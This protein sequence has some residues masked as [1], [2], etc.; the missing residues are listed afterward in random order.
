MSILRSLF[1]VRSVLFLAAVL[2]AVAGAAQPITPL[3]GYAFAPYD[4]APAG[5][6]VVSFDFDSSGDLYTLTGDPGWALGLTVYRGVGAGRTVLYDSDA[7]LPGSRV[8]V[9]GPWL[10]FNDGGDGGTRWDSNYYVL[11]LSGGAPILA[12]TTVEGTPSLWGA[13]T[14][15]GA[16]FFASGATG[17]GPSEIFHMPLSGTGALDNLVSIGQP[18]DASG[19]VAFDADGNLFYAPRYA[20]SGQPNVF[21]WTAAE[22][23]AALADPTGAPLLPAGHVWGE[24]PAPFTGASGM[25][26]DT[27]GSVYVTANVWGAPGELLVFRADAEGASLAPAALG[28]HAARLE[29]LRLRGGRVY[30]NC[31]EGVY[32]I[33]EVLTV[34]ADGPLE[35]SA[36]MGE[37]A[38]FSVTASGGSG[39]TAYEWHRVTAGKADTRVGT[40]APVLTVTPQWGD[41]GAQFYCLVSDAGTTGLASPVFTLDVTPMLPAAEGLGLAILAAAL[42]AA[43]ARRARRRSE[44]Q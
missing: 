43:G 20:Y 36:V 26:V 4:T 44:A 38:S 6:S 16:Q 10:Y 35:R 23:A 17:Y 31:A 19:P 7:A 15:N 22:V 3:T 42:A 27:A 8:T 28:R 1:P 33:P 30:V 24:I 11:P 18:G 12:Y 37:P 21:R 14:R 34:R 41:D 5:E 13:D 2:F 39:D 25:V 29:T 32:S 9:I 40:D